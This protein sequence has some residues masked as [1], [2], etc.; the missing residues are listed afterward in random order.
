MVNTLIVGASAAGLSCAAQLKRA[1][2]PFEI[3]EKHA[4][5]GQAWRNHY[6]RLH[7]H[8]N[9]SAS[10]LPYKKFPNNVSKYPSREEVIQY[11]EQYC[12]DMEI[13]PRFN[14]TVQHI[15]QSNGTWLTKTDRG[16]IESHSLIICTGNTNLPKEVV[17]PGMETF[18]GKI[19]HSSQYKNGK[20]FKG[21]QVLVVGFG[22]SA[23]EIAICLHEHGAFPSMSVRSPVNVIPR[24]ILGIPVLKLGILMSNLPPRMADTINKPLMGL[25]VGDIEKYGLKKLPYGPMEQI[26]KNRSVPLLDIGTMDLIKA[27][28]IKIFGDIL[29]IEGSHVQFLRDSVQFD[30]II[31]ATGYKTGLE[32]IISLDQK[33]LED[34]RLSIR[35]RKLLGVDDLYFCG[36][37]VSPSGMLREINLE[38][39]I[40]A[41]AIKR[42]LQSRQVEVTS[43]L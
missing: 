14:T 5:V 27:G 37:H 32:E 10:N 35:K 42:K 7:L 13:S 12:S 41:E 4:N 15:E 29:A 26:A 18:P 40:I 33:R 19:I 25:L 20:E 6:H 16:V 23:C 22:N 11:L 1:G 9:K 28:S 3:V 30:A 36:F 2:V 31:F 8:T 21:K 43:V 39:Q 24:D 17:K 38:S 34:I